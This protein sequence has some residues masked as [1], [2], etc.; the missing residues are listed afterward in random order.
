MSTSRKIAWVLLV[1]SLLN[2]ALLVR[3]WFVSGNP[4]PYVL[5]TVILAGLIAVT[6]SAI[7]REQKV[8]GT[9]DHVS[10]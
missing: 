3:A 4:M 8:Q 7:V 1:L 6:S 2:L 5:A 10:T 9:S